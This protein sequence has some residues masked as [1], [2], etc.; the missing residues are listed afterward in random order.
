MKKG[1]GILAALAFMLS[2]AGC[3]NFD[4]IAKG[5]YVVNGIE[6][7]DNNQFYVHTVDLLL[8]YIDDSDKDGVKSLLCNGLKNAESIDEDIAALVDG[9]EGEIIRTTEHEYNT[10]S[11]GSYGAKNA[12]A[13]LSRSFYIITD[14]QKYGAY[15][16]VCPFDEKHD[17]GED[18][19]GVYAIGIRTLDYMA[20]DVERTQ[21]GTAIEIADSRCYVAH[22]YGDGNNY[23]V[24]QVGT[25]YDV[26]ELCRIINPESVI[27]YDDLIAWN[28][29]DFGSFQE[30]FGP[31]YS[32]SLKNSRENVISDKY[33]YKISDSDKYAIVVVFRDSG[34]INVLSIKDI[35]SRWSEDNKYE[36]I[37]EKMQEIP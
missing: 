28:S 18:L 31:P 7:K 21:Y 25:Q 29:R 5:E 26:N 32:E 34:I 24:A 23:L 15:I 16:A 10:L 20:G 35:E 37:L 30:K 19:V 33:I 14:K 9:F 12:S 8:S 11:S 17:E 6:Y 2:L 27:N 22:Y 1:R 13:F 36:Y 3:S 4:A